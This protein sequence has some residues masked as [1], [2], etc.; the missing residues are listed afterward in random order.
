[1]SLPRLRRRV[2][3]PLFAQWRAA[4]P[5]LT[6]SPWLDGAGGGAGPGADAAGDPPSARGVTVPPMVAA[7]LALHGDPAVTVLFRLR[8]DAGAVVGVVALEDGV[9]SAL[10]RYGPAAPAGERAGEGAAETSAWVEVALVPIDRA[11]SEVLRWVPARPAVDVGLEVH[12]VRRR[13]R[14]VGS[15]HW[16]LPAPPEEAGGSV[17]AQAPGEQ[18]PGP[19][20]DVRADV[21]RALTA[22][23]AGCLARRGAEP[24][25]DAA[26]P[27]E[28]LV[29]VD[30]P[31]PSWRAAG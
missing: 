6:L 10:V 28:G 11:V 8:D 18:V 26:V 4:L 22:C 2:E 12:V 20:P 3:E 30:G 5:G 16:R 7:A 17:V 25:G 23:L 9:V 13:G 21:Q 19:G 27:V 29:P 14:P 24:P 1:V 31:A 15:W